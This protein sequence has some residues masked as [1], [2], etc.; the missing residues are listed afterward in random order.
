MDFKSLIKWG[1]LMMLLSQ[2]SLSYGQDGSINPFELPDRIPTKTS[3]NN[4]QVEPI[5]TNEE[6][7]PG[8]PFDLAEGETENKA[9]SLVEESSNPFNLVNPSKKAEEPNVV[10]KKKKV[11][12]K[13]AEP[14][15]SD[16]LLFVLL[17]IVLAYSAFLSTFSLG[18][19]RKT[20]DAF[21][22]F[23]MSN[24]MYRDQQGE[25]VSWKS[26]LLYVLYVL[27]LG[28]FLYLSL[29]LF[30]VNFI[31][32]ATLRLLTCIGIVAFEAIFRH[33]VL[34]F[35]TLIFPFKKEMGHYNFN[36]GVFNQVI[37]IVMIPF[38]IFLAFGPETMRVYGFWLG[39][40]LLGIIYCYRAI[41]GLFI[42]EKYISVHKFHFLLYLCT[43]EI[44]PIIVLIKFCL[45]WGQIESI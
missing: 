29:S 7:E 5:N 43:V 28:T 3:L 4:V 18:Q 21:L 9:I 31:E 13:P 20:F 37:G 42:A 30:Q 15:K 38:F 36:I 41:R 19:I 39:I 16:W 11:V 1:V 10:S 2:L 12:P 22:R 33:I 17:I 40:G 32:S 8:N 23:N 35:I 25:V 6:E 34:S 14:K 27:V 26:I 24:L 44:A 45:L